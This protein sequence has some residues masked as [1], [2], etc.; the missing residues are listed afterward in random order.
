MYWVF[1]S[2]MLVGYAGLSFI[3][4]DLKT[5]LTGI[6]LTITNAVIFFK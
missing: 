4:P 6:L 5:K 2:L 1:Y 3:A